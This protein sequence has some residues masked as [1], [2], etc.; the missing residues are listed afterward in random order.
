MPCREGLKVMLDKAD[1]YLWK[2]GDKKGT[3]NSLL[4]WATTST[5]PLIAGLG[6]VPGKPGPFHD[7]LFQT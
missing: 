7:P 4:N 2:A 3:W 1:R 5:A 6:R